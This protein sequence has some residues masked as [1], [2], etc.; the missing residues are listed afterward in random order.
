MLKKYKLRSYNFRLL[1]LIL[2]T[3]VF[4]LT[5]VNSANSSYTV[6]QGLGVALSIVIMLVISFVDYNFI[7][8]F[9]WLY[10]LVDIILLILVLK[11]GTSSHG[12][13]RWISIGSFSLQPSEFNKIIMI[14]VCCKIISMYKEKLN[15]WKFLL[16]LAA[17]LGLPLLLVV[18]EPSL[19]TTVLTTLVLLTIIFCAGIDYKI[20]GKVILVIVPLTIVL[21]LYISN[22][23]QKLL[24]DYQ[25]NR[26]MTFFSSEGSDTDEGKYQQ[27]Y[28]VKAIGSGQLN[29]KGLNNDDP[30][31]L[32]NAKYIAEAQNDFIFA[33]IG[34]ELGFVG[35]CATIFLLSWIVIECIIAAVRAKDFVGRL[36][37]CGA[38]AYI[39]F[40][41]FINIGVVTEILP[42]TGLPL[43]F[44]SCGIT[45]T[46]T[47]F[48]SMG[49][50]LNICLQRNTLR[51]DDMFAEDFRG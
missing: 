31:S 41:S 13:Q 33:V 43:P 23:N 9:Y 46:M 39:G 5:I 18:I 49:V 51:E 34:E 50:V 2:I 17:V 3:S 8:K 7:L 25:R 30:S 11:V 48:I 26:I 40:Q 42:N 44:F 12:A 16:V 22:P 15:T 27:E 36:I 47:V 10:Y 32:K 20:I 6:K 24:K 29:G 14:L 21:G 28:S 45:S 35:C 37:C 1:F 38:A 19:S 4:G